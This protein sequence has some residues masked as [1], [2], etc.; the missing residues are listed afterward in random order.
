MAVDSY[1]VSDKRISGRHSL[2]QQWSDRGFY[3]VRAIVG[4]TANLLLLLGVGGAAWEEAPCLR[5]KRMAA[6]M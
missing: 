4:S 6:S 3:D 1:F 5:R 2:L